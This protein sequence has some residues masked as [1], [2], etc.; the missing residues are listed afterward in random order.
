MK[1]DCRECQYWYNAASKMGEGE[2]R[3]E[4]ATMD[5]R[6]YGVWPITKSNGFCHSGLKKKPEMLNEHKMEYP[7]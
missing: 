2:C 3:S 5:N 1:V 4:P 6:G 7:V